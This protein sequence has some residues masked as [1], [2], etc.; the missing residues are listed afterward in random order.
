MTGVAIEIQEN[1]DEVK[2]ILDRIKVRFGRLTPAHQIIGAAVRTSVVRNFEKGGRPEK[3]EPLSETT[4]ARRKGKRVLLRQGFAG[5]LMGS[6]HY[7]AD[8][9]KVVIGT[10]KIYGA[11]HQ[12]G[13]KKGSFGTFTIKIPEHKRRVKTK[14]GIRKITVKAHTKTMALPWGDIP[15]RPFLL[16]QDEDW[17]LIRRQ[18][19]EY[20]MGDGEER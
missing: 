1:S 4:L 16:V 10:N 9:D 6:I 20:L 5:G 15:A 17:K 12:F 14:K 19:T 8:E 3:W 11:V 18:L 7:E 13:A 2:E